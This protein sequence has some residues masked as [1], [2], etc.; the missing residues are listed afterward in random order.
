MAELEDGTSALVFGA[1]CFSHFYADEATLKSTSLPADTVRLAL[2]YGITAFD[3]SRYYGESEVVLG[4]ALKDVADEFPRESYKIMTKCGRIAG[5]DFDYSPE[6]IRESVLRSLKRLQTTYLDTVYLHDIE[7]V[8]TPYAPR[9]EG[10]HLGAL[11]SYSIK[12]DLLPTAQQYN[13][14]D[15]SVPYGLAPGDEPTIRGPGDEQILAAF[16]EL[17]KL[18]AEGLVRRIGITGYPLPTLLRLALLIKA[19]QGVDEGQSVGSGEQAAPIDALLSYCHLTLQ[20][21]ALA[22]FAPHL[23]RRAG[24]ASVL[25][26]SP[27]SMGLLTSAGAPKWHPAPAGLREAQA[28]AAEALKGEG[29]ELADVALGYSLRAGKGMPLVVGLS[30]PREVHENVRVWREVLAEGDQNE[31]RERRERMVREM[32]K[33]AGYMDWSWP[34]P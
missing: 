16:A 6:G 11:G 9:S 4:Q 31:V 14:P 33:D 29:V 23:V 7:F 22:G 18:K 26:A 27:F 12:D 1:A 2:R 30:N 10:N 3:T 13:L 19:R 34:S 32:I 21:A 17:R 8:A 25:N 24:V 20:N 15:E 5:S 28:K